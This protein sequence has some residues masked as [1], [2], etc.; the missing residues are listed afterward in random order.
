GAQILME[1]QSKIKETTRQLTNVESNLS[2]RERERRVCELTKKELSALDP[3]TVAY[4][5]VGRMFV[6]APLP[7]LTEQLAKRVTEAASEVTALERVSKKLERDLLD[8][9]NNFKEIM[10]R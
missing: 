5:S 3:A 10:S 2:A 8:Q 1:I 4:S 7:K 6:Q 9:Q